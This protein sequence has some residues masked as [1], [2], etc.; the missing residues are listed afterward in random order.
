MAAERLYRALPSTRVTELLLEVHRWTGFADCFTHLHTGLPADDPRVVITALLADATNMGLTRMAD[1]C[2]LAS[3][4]Q[5]A[6]TAGWYLREDTYR[7]AL[8]IVASAQQLEPLAAQF[9]AANVSSSDRQHFLTAG[10]GE[11]LGA[12]NARYGH[13]R[14]ALE[15]DCPSLIRILR[16]P[17]W[18]EI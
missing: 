8:T 14:S 17:A 5:L 11:A 10:P 13:E 2:A 1:A 16:I 12:H 6:W 15:R 4:K 3:Y 7:S 18:A 9:G